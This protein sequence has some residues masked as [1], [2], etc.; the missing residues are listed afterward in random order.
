MGFRKRDPE[1]GQRLPWLLNTRTFMNHTC[2]FVYPSVSS[3]LPPKRKNGPGGG[4]GG[5]EH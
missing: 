4:G 5:A 2:M 1:T 3:R